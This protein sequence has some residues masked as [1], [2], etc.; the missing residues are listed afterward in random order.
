MTVVKFVKR[1]GN[2]QRIEGQTEDNLRQAS[3]HLV[4]Q[5]LEILLKRKDIAPDF[6]DDLTD[7]GRLRLLTNEPRH[8]LRAAAPSTS[9]I[10]MAQRLGI[11]AVDNALAGYTDFMIS[12]WLTE[13]VLV[14]LDL[15]VLG[16]KR[17]PEDGIFWKS[18]IAKTGQRGSRMES[19][20]KD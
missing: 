14:P 5:A 6:H 18:V 2:G 9:D 3:L 19:P 16:R 4:T 12:Q 13:Y 11:L 8:L 1:H 10:T 7:W 15:V 17:I 20:I